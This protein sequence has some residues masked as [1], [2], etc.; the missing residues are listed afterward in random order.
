MKEYA[1]LVRDAV[2]NAMGDNYEVQLTS[3]LKNNGQ[4]QKCLII[5]EK[6]QNTASVAYLN[7]YYKDNVPVSEAVDDIIRKY[8]PAPNVSANDI[9]NYDNVKNK[10]FYQLVNKSSN[11]DYLLDKP[12]KDVLDDLVLI[13]R[14]L[15]DVDKQTGRVSSTVITNQLMNH[16]GVTL[17]ELDALSRENTPKLFPPK[18]QDLSEAFHIPSPTPMFILSNTMSLSGAGAV[19]YPDV[20][21]SIS[22]TINMLKS[23]NITM[24]PSSIHE[25]IL[26]PELDDEP[27]PMDELTALINYVNVSSLDAEEVLSNHPYRYL[28]ETNEIVSI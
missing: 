2:A 7:G 9:I 27:M 12:H 8:Q 19:L 13:Y 6:E 21:G 22:H 28:H 15:I 1:K 16:L 3:V 11:T 24:I 20:M 14:V 25:W 17:E 18:I 4:V 26:V 23:C 5:K 10:I